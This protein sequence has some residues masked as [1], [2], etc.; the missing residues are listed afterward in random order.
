MASIYTTGTINQPDAGSVGLAMVE[1]IRDDAVAHAAWDLVEEFTPAS[2]QVR[3]YVLKCLGSL[4][5]LGSDFFVVIGRTLANGELRFAICEGYNAGSHQMTY[6]G[7]SD[8]SSSPVMDALGRLPVSLVTTLGTT[9]LSGSTNLAGYQYW[10]PS[11]T[12]TKWWI[13][14]AED[15]LS[16]AFNGA[17]NSFIHVGVYT[18]LDQLGNVFPVQIIGG[19]DQSGYMTRNPAVANITLTSYT[20]A[21]KFQGGGSQS[22]SYLV[23]LGFQG[24][25]QY[26]DKLQNNQRPVSEVGMQMVSYPGKSDW[27][28]VYGYALGKQKRMRFSAQVMPGGFAF[29][30]AF[31]LN[32]TLW[33]PWVPNWGMIFDTGVASS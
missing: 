3:W 5:G 25:W 1:K 10:V 24:S 23:P 12:S 17:S 19:N 31:A 9:N 8:M 2:G 16:I 13:I 32:G 28:T 30:D 21:L 15:T 7:I 18:P 29:G 14:V 11:G 20:Y 33:V 27:P 22:S 4:N 26:N 6:Y